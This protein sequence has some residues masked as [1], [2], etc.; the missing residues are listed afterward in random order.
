MQAVAQRDRLADPAAEGRVI[1]TGQ[2][3]LHGQ[4]IR[5]RIHMARISDQV[6]PD[7]PAWPCQTEVAPPATGASTICA[8]NR[9][10]RHWQNIGPAWP[11]TASPG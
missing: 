11:R 3:P 10:A 6:T 4:P 1:G 5:G 9:A 8:P 2:H 7:L